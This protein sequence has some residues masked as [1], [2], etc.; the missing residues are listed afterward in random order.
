MKSGDAGRKSKGRGIYQLHV[1]SVCWMGEKKMVKVE[2]VKK[3][4]VSPG[5]C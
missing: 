2:R 1:G 5:R 3:E 4:M